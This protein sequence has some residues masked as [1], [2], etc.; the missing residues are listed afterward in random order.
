MYRL[1]H[2]LVRLATIGRVLLRHGALSPLA[3]AGLA[4]ALLRPLDRLVAADLRGLRAGERLG[5]AALTLGPTFVKTGQILAT[6]PDLVGEEMA[7]DLASLQDRLPPFPGARA[8]A[9]LEEEFGRP[10]SAL[11]RS[12]DDQAV[13][14]AS[15]A[16]V[17]FAETLDGRPV[18]VKLLRPG[19]E[20]QFQRDLDLFAW[21]ADM[22]ERMRP[23]LT[24]LR[25]REVVQTLRA[26]IAMEVDLRFEAAAAAEL[27]ANFRGD[28]SFVVPSIDWERTGR[29]VL[30]LERVGG[31]RV[32]DRAGLS[33][34][35]LDPRHVLQN[36]ARAFFNQVFR[37]GFFHA[38]MH[39]G[40]IFVGADG[41][42]IP[43]DFGIMGRVDR[44]T[45]YRLADMLLGFLT[46]DYHR[47][48]RVHFEAG[49]VPPHQSIETFTQAC[50]SIGEPLLGKPL[51]EISVAR[52]LAQLFEVTA[53]FE[54]RTQPQLLMLQKTMVQ[55]EGMGRLLDSSVNMWELARPLIEDW[56]IQHRGPAARIGQTGESIV[57]AAQRIPDVL[58][59]VDRAARDI[60]EGGVRLHPDTVERLADAL[61]RRR[62]PSWLPWLLALAL[63][64]G[65]AVA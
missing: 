26:A 14:A 48:A 4:P 64:I 21:V 29:R 45:R 7:R 41:R 13:A 23:E 50:R 49:Y 6:R 12:F 52:L 38:D 15:I 10:V 47:V 30:T 24:R 16:Q 33:A 28:D 8:R 60:S 61:S 25:P 40:N 35:G 53:T 36:S 34:A 39:P 46:A 43:I 31:L 3:E 20:Q 1:P 11:F 22:S 17:H 59:A 37:D 56:M 2:H 55:A 44:E 58:A 54:M 65:W 57:A 9:I 63:A 27:A 32:D 51:S 42:L 5:R 18:A 62:S 19:I